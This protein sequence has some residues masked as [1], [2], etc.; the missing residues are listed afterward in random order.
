MNIK[1]EILEISPRI[2]YLKNNPS[3]IFSVLFNSGKNSA[4][5]NDLEKAIKEQKNVN[6]IINQNNKI[7][8]TLMKNN[9]CIIGMAE[10]DPIDEI[11][12]VNIK[13]IKS[14][15]SKDNILSIS[16]QKNKNNKNKEF[17]ANNCDKDL[18]NKNN[19]YY[20]TTIKNNNLDTN[21]NNNAKKTTVNTTINYTDIFNNNIKIKISTK[22]N[23][24][25]KINI[26]KNKALKPSSA[27]IRGSSQIILNTNCDKNKTINKNSNNKDNS[28]KLKKKLKSVKS[29]SSIKLSLN[30]YITNNNL[31][32]NSI[33]TT[34]NS[35]N[36]NVLKLNKNKSLIDKKQNTQ[37]NFYTKKAFINDE[38]EN[39]YIINQNYYNNTITLETN[40]KK[41]EDLIIDNNFK[42]KLKSDEII[43]P[44]YFNLG[45]NNTIQINNISND[46]SIKKNTENINPINRDIL[47]EQ[48][49]FNN[50]KKFSKEKTEIKVKERKNNS[51]LNIP[52]M[53]YDNSLFNDNIIKKNKSNEINKYKQKISD[54]DDEFVKMF[55]IFKNDIIIYY[56]KEY[57]NSIKDDVLSLE[58]QLIFEKIINL[59]LEYQKQ[60]KL[61]FNNFINNKKYIK[62]IQKKYIDI[63]KKNSK[64]QTKK[65]EVNYLNKNSELFDLGNNQV[66][67]FGKSFLDNTGNELFN[68]L[69]NNYRD[70]RELFRNKKIDNIFLLICKKNI[71]KL[72]SLSK[73]YYLDI[74]MKRENRNKNLKE[75]YFS[76]LSSLITIQNIKNEKEDKNVK[77]RTLNKKSK[78][79]LKSTKLYQTIKTTTRDENKKNK[80]YFLTNLQS[81]EKKKSK[82]NKFK[83]Q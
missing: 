69:L 57:L 6:L 15:P 36:K 77:A 38:N 53:K 14:F 73:R 21:T 20:L 63:F 26:S 76:E 5:I 51:S 83:F 75:P 78:N 81:S 61:L 65:I 74:K 7:K 2:K 4:K 66:L 16:S 1:I 30:Q 40:N 32:L 29:S 25:S 50:Y 11:K 9:S 39:N 33:Y 47:K 80:K 24:K 27:L 43:N 56:T 18:D 64:L 23:S 49:P 58:L 48:I 35:N 52:S 79:N 37:Y 62:L 8:L 3:E 72:N 46:N 22:V 70:N 68:N 54:N 44:N 13:E 17:E 60:Y 42:N 67:L 28:I 71:N 31:S 12:W 55:E 34:I 41:I 45:N 19:D 10:F 59:K 82:K